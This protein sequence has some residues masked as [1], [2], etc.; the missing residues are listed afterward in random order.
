[1]KNSW[2]N[3]RS[4]TIAVHRS[5][6]PAKFEVLHTL[7][8]IRAESPTADTILVRLLDEWGVPVV[9]S[10]GVSVHFTGVS[11]EGEGGR[12][13]SVR[14]Q[15]DVE[16]WLK[17][18]VRGGGE[19]GRGLIAMAAGDAEFRQPLQ[20]HASVRLL[21]ATMLGRFGFGATEDG[22]YASIT[23]RGALD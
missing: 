23:A 13:R 3:E 16:G 6:R 18:V 9:N 15:P 8:I 19:C 22:N 17:V 14:L 5:G 2:G 7:D 1:M 10:P 12:R 21:I 4:D 20:V 11:V